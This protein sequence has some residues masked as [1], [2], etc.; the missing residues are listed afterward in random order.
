MM[1]ANSVFDIA[2]LT[3]ILI[4]SFVIKILSITNHRRILLIGKHKI[5]TKLRICKRVSW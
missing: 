2:G 1:E 3:R 4:T 5:F